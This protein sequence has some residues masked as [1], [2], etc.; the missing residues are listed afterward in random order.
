M[1][2]VWPFRS[3]RIILDSSGKLPFLSTALLPQH[4]KKRQD[5]YRK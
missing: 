5:Q 4:A 1:V 2:I 3:D